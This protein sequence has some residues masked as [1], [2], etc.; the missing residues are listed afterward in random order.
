M[1]VN[2]PLNAAMVPVAPPEDAGAE[3]RNVPVAP[4]AVSV[5]MLSV[6]LPCDWFAIQIAPEVVSIW[7]DV[8]TP[9][10]IVVVPTAAA[11]PKLSSIKLAPLLPLEATLMEPAALKALSWQPL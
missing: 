8:G 7:K 5:V 4:D 1:T 6:P 3:N 2:V 10:P 9:G 11:A